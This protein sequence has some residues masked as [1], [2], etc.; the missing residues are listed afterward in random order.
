MVEQ[1]IAAFEGIEEVER[2]SSKFVIKTLKDESHLL[3]DFDLDALTDAVMVE[4]D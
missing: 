4:D 3:N 2:T 1:L